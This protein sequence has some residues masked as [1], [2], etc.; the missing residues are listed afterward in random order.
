LKAKKKSLIRL[1]RWIGTFLGLFMV[2]FVVLL[3]FILKPR[4]IFK[5]ET[6]EISDK[7]PYLVVVSF[8]MAVIIAVYV[9]LAEKNHK[10]KKL[11]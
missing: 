2:C 8:I 1:L 3:G 5:Y 7:I 9:L 11:N 4:F 6:V 10:K